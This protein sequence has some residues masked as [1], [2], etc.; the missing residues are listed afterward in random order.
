MGFNSGFKG[1]NLEKL[2]QWQ[3]DVLFSFYFLYSAAA[4]N[5]S[6]RHHFAVFFVECLL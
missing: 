6:S 2:D 4:I 3:E 5:K 1:L